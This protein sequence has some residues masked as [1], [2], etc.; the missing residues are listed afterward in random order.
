MM[1]DMGESV[2]IFNCSDR[3]RNEGHAPLRSKTK[4]KT[5]RPT[6]ARSRDRYAP[7]ITCKKVQK[8]WKTQL[9]LHRRTGARKLLSFCKPAWKKSH[10]DL[11]FSQKSRHGEK[12]FSQL[13]NCSE[14]YRRNQQ[15]QSRNV[16]SKGSA[17]KDRSWHL[18]LKYP[19]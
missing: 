10:N 7:G 18:R 13:S 2:H 11:C 16:S 8:M 9:P 12:S 19:P 15:Y 3:N 17:V 5:A 4:T 1:R 6:N 14:N